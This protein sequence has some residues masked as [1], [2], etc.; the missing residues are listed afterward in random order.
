[1]WEE[2]VLTTTTKAKGK[3]WMVVIHQYCEENGL[4]DLVL[5]PLDLGLDFTM[6]PSF[7]GVLMPCWL[8]SSCVEV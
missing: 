3:K 1:M 8:Y 4:G 7:V 2:I 6:V 5:C